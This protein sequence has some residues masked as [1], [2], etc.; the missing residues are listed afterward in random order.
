[1]EISLKTTDEREIDLRVIE[2]AETEAG[3]GY[4]LVDPLNGKSFLELLFNEEGYK[5]IESDPA[6]DIADP[7]LDQILTELLVEL[8]PDE[9]SIGSENS[10]TDDEFEEER[11]YDPEKIRVEPKQFS[12]RQIYDMIKQDDIDLTPDF[13]RHLVWDNKRKSRLIESI[14]LRIPL[15]MF[16]FAQ[17]EDG[18]ISVVDGLQRLSTIKEFMDNKLRL[19][20]LEYLEDKCGGKYYNHESRPSIDQKYF[21]WFNMTQITV[22]VIDPSSPTKLKY[23][24]FRR[25]NT[26]GKPLNNQEIRNCLA[27]KSLRKLLHEMVNLDSFKLATGGSVKDVRMEAQELAL[28]FILFHKKYTSDPSLSSYTGNINSEL[29]SLTEELSKKGVELDHYVPLFDQSMKNAFYLFGKYSFRKNLLEH[30]KP[31]ARRQLINKALFV[32]WSVLLSQY[33][34]D[35]AK[36]NPRG[37]LV[38]PLAEKITNDE[39]LYSYLT[40]GTNAKAN[41]QAAFAAA[42]ELIST[43]EL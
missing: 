43:L 32:S 25:I 28:R 41:T 6:I 26:G 24:V 23:D 15:P 22:N 3:Q 11:P 9:S 21:R 38:E 8:S 2:G 34:I 14:L 5:I 17:D 33:D 40:Y 36:Q 13:Q 1:M 39:E 42:E 16:Y 30:L 20:D 29:N 35:Q 4:K 27:G 12:L 19:R 18:Y 10:E 37:S 7:S 31:S